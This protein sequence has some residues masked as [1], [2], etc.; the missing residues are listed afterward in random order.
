MIHLLFIYHITTSNRARVI[1]SPD[2]LNGSVIAVI[3]PHK[4]WKNP[5]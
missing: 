2:A 1:Y 5:V 4:I 3:N